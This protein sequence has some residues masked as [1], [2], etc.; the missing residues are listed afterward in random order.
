[1]LEIMEETGKKR[2]REEDGEGQD[3]RLKKRYTHKK[4]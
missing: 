2:W 3:E 1:M 4:N